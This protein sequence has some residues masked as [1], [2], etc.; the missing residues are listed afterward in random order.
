MILAFTSCSKD[1]IIEISDNTYPNEPD[2]NWYNSIQPNFPVVQLKNDIRKEKNETNYTYLGT[3]NLSLRNGLSVMITNGGLKMP[4]GTD[5]RGNIQVEWAYPENKGGI[6]RYLAACGNG[7]TGNILGAFFIQF[8]KDD[9]TLLPSAN[10]LM[11]VT[12]APLEQIGNTDDFDLYN[13]ANGVL[14]SNDVFWSFITPTANNYIISEFDR[15]K[16]RTNKTGW[17]MI[18]HPEYSTQGI[19]VK[20]LLNSIYTN[21]NTAA[22]LI[23]RE[24]A[25]YLK[26]DILNRSFY[27]DQVEGNSAPATLMVISRMGDSYY[28]GKRNFILSQATAID[29]I[30]PVKTSLLAIKEYLDSLQ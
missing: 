7:N 8:K 3:L 30:Y 26:S 9:I 24:A 6:I 23:T 19:T 10:F 14:N 16:I 29:S 22:Y 13:S 21:S 4:D 17:F 5:A 15:L 28:M 25:Y 1:S 18:A 27:I 12:Y 20:P 2:L 11:E